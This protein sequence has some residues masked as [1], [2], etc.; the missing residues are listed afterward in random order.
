M[1]RGRE[2]RGQ[3][4][5]FNVKGREEE[6]VRGLMKRRTNEREMGKR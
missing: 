2:D 1:Y 3:R 5:Y 4:K 6:R